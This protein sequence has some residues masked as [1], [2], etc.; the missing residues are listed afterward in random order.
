MTIRP[1]SKSP[2]RYPTASGKPQAQ[3][4]V[5]ASGAKE[6][7]KLKAET[8]APTGNNRPKVRFTL[9]EHNQAKWCSEGIVGNTVD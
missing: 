3:T 6:V 5:P 1:W 4:D 7:G 2:R 8:S 9:E